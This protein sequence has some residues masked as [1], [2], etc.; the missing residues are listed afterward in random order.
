MS[1]S[2][3]PEETLRPFRAKADRLMFTTLLVLLLFS[4]CIAA[5][6]GRWELVLAIG[7]PAT[8]VPGLLIKLQPGSVVSRLAVALAFMVFAALS[9]QT[10][11]GVIEAHFGIFV[12]LAF[13]LYYRD[14]KPIIAAAAAIAI[15][16]LLFNYLQAL[17]WGV[18]LFEAGPSLMRVVFHA[19]YVVI[20]AGLLTYMAVLMQRESMEAAQV[21][22]LAAAI[23]AGD[24]REP[25]I[26]SKRSELLASIATMQRNLSATLQRVSLE[27]KTISSSA[28][29]LDRDSS[30]AS[31]RMREQ[32][33]AIAEISSSIQALNGEL[34]RL[35]ADAEAARTLAIESGESSRNGARIVQSAVDE[36]TGIAHIIRQS[37]TSV[38]QLG[39][40]SDRVAEV[41]GL[42]KDIAGQTN[43]LALNAA[44]EAARAGEQGRG[45]AVV[46]DEVR[47]LAER[48]AAA[49]EEIG[50]MIRDIQHSKTQALDN[51]ESAVERVANGTRLAANAGESIGQITE[52]A[53][54]VEMVF[55][56]IANTLREQSTAAHRMTDS[57]ESVAHLADQTEAS[58]ANVASAVETLELG[59]RALSEAVS[60]FR[61]S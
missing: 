32:K 34:D 12:L 40:Q 42:I 39:N 37:A 6:S 61:L 29:S 24:L 10:L 57:I 41:V 1:R 8:L 13:L 30:D 11:D 14:W 4:L 19:L 23:G 18:Y 55:S 56:S 60:G 16:H 33:A 36:I 48:T 7:L 2:A 53:N 9:I 38:E 3:S 15:H 31:R 49:T 27:A 26:D 25:A 52:G 44:I 17:N 54:R 28:S 35:S 50:S 21:S 5:Y 43:L 47:K 46:A 22:R 59:A 51:I 58:A 20:E 45:F